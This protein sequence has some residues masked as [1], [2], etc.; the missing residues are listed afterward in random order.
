MNKF[1]VQLTSLCFFMLSCENDR[2]TKDESSEAMAFLKGEKTASRNFT[3]VVWV[4]MLVHPDTAFNINA[5]N[6]TFEPGAR[7][8]WHI[9]PGG[10]VLLI[11]GGKGRYQEQGTPV[12]E[13]QKGDVIKCSPNI[14]H[15][16]GAV[17]DSEM[18]HLA[19]GTNQHKGPVVWLNPVSDK[20]YNGR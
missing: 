10:Q 5:G 8:N 17:P 13:I 9:H 18:S 3:G 2:Q 19:I 12:R 1:L 7:T 15:W 11:T 4:N 14:P 20:E 6:V 16:H